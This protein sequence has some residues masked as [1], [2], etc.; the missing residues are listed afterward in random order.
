MGD[1]KPLL[2]MGEQSYTLSIGAVII[3]ALLIARTTQKENKIIKRK[4]KEWKN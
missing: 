3:F 2:N 1:N 4:L